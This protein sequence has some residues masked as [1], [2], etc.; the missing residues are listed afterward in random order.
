MN[1]LYPLCVKLQ[2]KK[3]KEL[4]LVRGVFNAASMDIYI[5]CHLRYCCLLQWFPTGGPSPQRSLS[6]LSGGLR[7]I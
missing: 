1:V 3:K 4:S 6:K 7:L 5:R 2:K